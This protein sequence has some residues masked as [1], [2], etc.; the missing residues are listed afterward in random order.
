MQRNPIAMVL[1]LILS[2]LAAGQVQAQSS[3]L[4][5]L[6]GEVKA[7]EDTLAKTGTV[8]D[9]AATR[10][11]KLE[12]LFQQGG[13]HKEIA[14]GIEDVRADLKPIAS[15]LNDVRRDLA[16]IES[17]LIDMRSSASDRKTILAIRELRKRVDAAQAETL[18]QQK[19]LKQTLSRL[20]DLRAKLSV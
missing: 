17:T 18:A 12:A 4:E 5:V 15:I 16:D 9:K 1:V 2:L 11:D 10:T 20:S 14:Q 13:S 19:L 8:I 6:A 7:I 3:K